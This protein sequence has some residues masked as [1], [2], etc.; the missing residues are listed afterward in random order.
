M[1]IALWSLFADEV[2]PVI[3]PQTLGGGSQPGGYIN[4]Y[5]RRKRIG[6][7]SS[8][9]DRSTSDVEESRLTG[10]E[11]TEAPPPKVTPREKKRLKKLAEQATRRG[12]DQ[13]TGLLTELQGKAAQEAAL[14][15]LRA[16]G[17][18]T[19]L[20][21]GVTGYLDDDEEEALLL[22]ALA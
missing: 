5:P 7:D 12:F 13:L 9:S 21:T 6:T 20:R 17:P 14:S 11:I 1:L 15:S 22:L 10:E 8:A 2:W 4:R 19:S 16:A 18:S 3:A